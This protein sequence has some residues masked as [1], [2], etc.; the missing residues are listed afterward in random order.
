MQSQRDAKEDT[1]KHPGPSSDGEECKRQ[2]DERDPVVAIQ[3][4][5]EAVLLEIGYVPG[6]QRR[7]AVG[8]CTVNDP[9]CMRPPCAL[10]R[11]VRIARPVCDL[12]MHA[13]RG[14]PYQW[15]PF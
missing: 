14:D 6:E 4:E 11:R 2:H 10:A 3:P 7:L 9:P 5:V 1:P 15:A 8:A 12:V 13:M